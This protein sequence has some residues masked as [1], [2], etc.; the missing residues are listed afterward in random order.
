M[1]RDSLSIEGLRVVLFLCIFFF[2]AWREAFPL[3][4]AG[5][6]FFL[7]ITAYFFTRKWLLKPKSEVHIKQ[8]LWKRALRLYP[9]YLI[10]V[11]AMTAMYFVGKRQLPGDFF[12]YFLFAQNFQIEFVPDTVQVPGA[13]HFWYLTLDFYLV[14]IW[15]FVFKYIP[16]QYV[17]LSFFFLLIFAVVYRSVSAYYAQSITLSYIMPWGMMDAFAAGGLLAFMN[18]ENQKLKAPWI[19]LALGIIIFAFCV[20][21]TAER[22]DVN[23]LDALVNYCSARGYADSP[24]TIQIHLAMASLAFFTVWVCVCKRK[25]YGVLSN[26]LL[27]KLG[28]ASYELYVFHYPIIKGVKMA[29]SNHILIITI[30]LIA[31][32]AVTVIWKRFLEAK[33]IVLF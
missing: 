24:I 30:G 13:G 14:M 2:H 29:T 9:S 6:N 15:L 22:F 7:V 27:A 3:G 32:F 25:H 18:V 12:S 4:W 5:I 19:A 17:Q 16:R 21:T 28:G 8:A 20:Y 1:Q 31:T 10:V 11:L 23:V 33:V 26:G